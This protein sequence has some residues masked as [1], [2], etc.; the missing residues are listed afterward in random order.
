MDVS[1]RG[2]SRAAGAAIPL[3]GAA[4]QN[5]DV[6]VSRGRRPAPARIVHDVADPGTRKIVRKT[7][8]MSWTL[9]ATKYRVTLTPQER[10]RLETLTTTGTAPARTL[11]HAR[12]LLKADTRLPL[13]PAWT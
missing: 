9:T 5:V 8:A 1:T 6:I 11:T 12:I 7:F 10:D 2:T 3:A 4:A 13:G